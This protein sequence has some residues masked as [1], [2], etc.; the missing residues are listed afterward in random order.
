M[1]K[2]LGDLG[3]IE[4]LRRTN[5]LLD[6]RERARYASAVLLT[7][8]RVTPRLLAA[9]LGLKGTGPD[10]S[11]LAP[12]DTPLVR[13]VLDACTHLDPMLIGHGVRSYLYA[14]ALGQ[15]DGIDVDPEALFVA[16]VL[17]DYAFHA[18]EDVTDRCF[19]LVGIDVAED[20]LSSRMDADLLHDAL[21]AMT[22]HA[23][24]VVRRSQGDL[25]HL[26]HAGVFVDVLGL[27][28]WH[29]DPEGV[30]RVAEVHPRHGFST[31]GRP[32]FHEHARRVPGGRAAVAW[33]CGF[34]LAIHLGPWP[35]HERSA[36]ATSAPA[37][38]T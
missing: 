22:L 4:W 23:N 10:P 35:A 27:R 5:G 37:S 36:I 30:R 16:A 9:R 33:R 7:T 38:R 14:R 13:E 17:H 3:T 26:L 8:A 1:T 19:T 29:L 31:R 25:Q 2:L 24:P 12:P 20:L 6:R 15:R 32:I 11:A 34:G 21:D 28:R 18:I